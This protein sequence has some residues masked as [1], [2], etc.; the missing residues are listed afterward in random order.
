MERDRRR[1][2]PWIFALS[3]ATAISSA[4]VYKWV[5]E[6]GRAHYSDSPPETGAQQID[7]EP[8]PAPEEIQ[9]ANEKLKSLL[10][11]QRE[12]EGSRRAEDQRHRQAEQ[13]ATNERERQLDRCIFVEQQVLKLQLQRPVYRVAGKGEKLYV[14][15][16]GERA[17]L[18]YGAFGQPIF[19]EK[20]PEGER[21]FVD[22][23]GRAEEIARYTQERA[24]YCET[25]VQEFKEA[26]TKRYRAFM[27]RLSTDSLAKISEPAARTSAHDLQLAKGYVA[28]YCRD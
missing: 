13:A 3:L 8:G 17:G 12:Q 28:R 20:A 2:L 4:G 21:I 7:T 6:Q 24:S 15:F 5:D 1:L 11:K 16:R 26:F 27:C 14:K 23:P 9:R 22:D 25:D 10:E 19:I 18:T